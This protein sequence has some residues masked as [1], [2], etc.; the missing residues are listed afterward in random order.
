MAGKYLHVNIHMTW[1]TKNRI[2][3]LDPQW[4]GRLYAFLNSIAVAKKARLIEA[5]S[6]PDHIHLYV[7]MPSTI[8][9]AEMIN[10]FKSNSSRWIHE[11]FP[12]R[13]LFSWQEGY[14][15]FSIGRSEEQAVIRYI[16]NQREHHRKYDF[17]QEFIDLLRRYGIEYDI[18]YVFD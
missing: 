5:N 15:A 2:R 7:S 4:A 1:S 13:R 11:S 9:I 6:E 16:R 14:A 12:N 18:R 3:S 10:A 17:Q 8:A